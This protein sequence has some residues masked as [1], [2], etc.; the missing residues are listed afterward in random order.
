MHVLHQRIDGGDQLRAGWTLEYRAVIAHPQ[1][2]VAA[3][4]AAAAEVTADEIEFRRR[5]RIGVQCSWVR[6]MRAARSSTALTNLWPSV[7]PKRR[8]RFTPP[9]STT[10]KG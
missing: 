8:G 3:R 6:R 7:T 9:V 5:H 2:H 4:R 1:D 10:R